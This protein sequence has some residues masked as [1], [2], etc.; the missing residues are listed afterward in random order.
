MIAT[1]KKRNIFCVQE[2]VDNWDFVDNLF[3]FMFA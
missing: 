2:C 1:Q 3:T